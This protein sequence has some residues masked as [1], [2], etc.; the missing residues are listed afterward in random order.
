ML[1]GRRG[2]ARQPP[3]ACANDTLAPSLASSVA[4][5]NLLV[6]D[7]QLAKHVGEYLPGPCGAQGSGCRL[8]VQARGAGSGC[9]LG[10][11]ARG[12]GSGC[13]FRVQVRVAGS[14]FRADGAA[15]PRWGSAA[16]LALGGCAQCC[17]PAA[18]PTRASIPGALTLEKED[19]N[20]VNATAR[21]PLNPQRVC[22]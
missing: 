18:H 11:Q 21:P 1:L 9:R 13:R 20:G 6:Y 14:G 12:A 3:T 4:C 2:A 16:A 19:E 5:Q 7:T 15:Q 22:L 8:G 10:V 17:A